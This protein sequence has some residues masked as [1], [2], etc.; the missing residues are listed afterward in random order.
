MVTLILSRKRFLLRTLNTISMNDRRGFVRTQGNLN[1]LAGVAITG[2]I[3]VSELDFV[4]VSGNNIVKFPNGLAQGLQV[5]DTGANNY[6]TFDS[7]STRPVVDFGVELE[8]KSLLSCIGGLIVC[9]TTE[10]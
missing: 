1:S 10:Y 3:P 6:V 2:P 8:A 4:S 7:R 9:Y 5:V